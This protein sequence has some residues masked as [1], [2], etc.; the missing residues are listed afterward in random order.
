[1]LSTHLS[2]VGQR[3]FPFRL[4]I[5][6][7]VAFFALEWLSP[8]PFFGSHY[9]AIH[10]LA[11]FVVATG[12][13]LRAWAAGT[14]GLHT[15]SARIEAP[16]LATG[17]PFAHLRNPIYTGSICIGIGMSLLIGDPLAFLFTAV[18][19]A[20]LYVAIIPAEEAFL[21]EQFG[22]QYRDYFDAVPRLL[23]RL[24]PWKHHEKAAFHWRAALGEF[25]IVLILPA[26]YALLLLEEYL[27]KLG[28]S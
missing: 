28:I 17:G 1:M 6:L 5:G 25:W 14:A 22:S 21:R 13:G 4:G 11:L 3:I 23:P 12:V 2:R 26:I 7:L 27:D 16:T 9:K 10:T 15:R 24:R 20:I 8:T 18:A 19:F